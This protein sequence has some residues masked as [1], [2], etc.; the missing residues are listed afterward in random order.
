[1]A[2]TAAPRKSTSLAYVNVI[3]GAKGDIKVDGTAVVWENLEREL[4]AKARS[5][6]DRT[7]IVIRCAE[8]A[9]MG[10]LSDLHKILVKTGLTKVSYQD[11]EGNALA[12]ILPGEREKE[13]LKQIDP[14]DVSTLVIESEGGVSVDGRHV[15]IP[16]VKDIVRKLLVRNPYLVVSI[17]TR[18]DT[19]YSDFHAVL[20]QVKAAGA[21]RI[22]VG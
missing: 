22:S 20:D 19:E 4:E 10:S 15:T 12:L 17:R 14:D 13:I 7:V 16:E 11:A 21:E 2:P 6:A 9:K 1:M 3:V 8:G 5:D 18:L